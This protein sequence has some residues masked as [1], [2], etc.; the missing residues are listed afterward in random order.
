[1]LMGH[2]P[3]IYKV[4]PLLVQQER[5]VIIPLDEPKVLAFP[6]PNQNQSSYF[7]PN[8]SFRGGGTRG[9]RS[10]GG[11]GRGTRVCIHYGMTYHTVDTCFKKHGRWCSQ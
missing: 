5:Q 8:P 4:Y 2:L 9:G 11:G 7:K 3:N 1:M 6:T 10:F